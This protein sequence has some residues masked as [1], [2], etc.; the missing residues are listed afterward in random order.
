MSIVFWNSKADKLNGDIIIDGGFTKLFNELNTEG[1]YRYV[2]NIIAWTTQFSRRIGECGDNWI[3]VFKIPSFTQEINYKE[4]W[5]GFKSQRY[6]NEFDIIYMIDATG[7]MTDYIKAAKDEVLNISNSLNEKFSTLNFNFGCIFYRDPIDDKNDIHE[8]FQLTN[9]I[10][11][12]QNRMSKVEA[13]GGGDDSEDWV[14][15]YDKVLHD[16]GWR[17][18]T[19]LVIHIADAPAHGKIFNEKDKYEE[20]QNKLQ[21]LIVKCAKKEIKI[22]SFNIKKNA[23]KCFEICKKYYD[24]QGGPLYKIYEFKETS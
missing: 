18:G 21:P 10:K 6:S 24:K 5:S 20:E 2:Q 9:D 1:T 15:A 14:G 13:K 22:I 8:L 19:K 7:S 11:T 3:E 23:Q 16:I 12:L 17:N 4:V